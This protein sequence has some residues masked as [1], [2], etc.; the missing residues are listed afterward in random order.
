VAAVLQEQAG[1]EAAIT[2]GRRGE[3]TVW[4][5]DRQVAQKDQHGFPTEPDIVAAV[6]QA[7][8]AQSS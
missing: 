8:A 4:V 1:I 6:R 2:P 7:L 3:F 5:G